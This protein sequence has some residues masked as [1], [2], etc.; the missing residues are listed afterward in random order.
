V[1]FEIVRHHD[2]VVH[3]Y[4]NVLSNLLSQDL[5]HKSLV[6]CPDIF[7]AERHDII[8]IVHCISDEGS[9]SVV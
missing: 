2:Y 1:L 5:V 9:L 8:T 3:I 6:R 4:L 7:E